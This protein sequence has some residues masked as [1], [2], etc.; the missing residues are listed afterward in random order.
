[1]KRMRLASI[2]EHLLYVRWSLQK[3]TCSQCCTVR[4]RTCLLG[5]T[6]LLIELRKL[7]LREVNLH[8]RIHT[9]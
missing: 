5:T 1:M 2:F 9:A 7:R 3:R 4:E 6:I 8:A